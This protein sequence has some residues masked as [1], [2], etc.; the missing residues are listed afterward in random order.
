ML[1]T[2]GLVRG[3]TKLELDEPVCDRIG[4]APDETL[5]PSLINDLFKYVQLIFPISIVRHLLNTQLEFQTWIA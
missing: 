1:N 4:T 3:S 2:L 5:D